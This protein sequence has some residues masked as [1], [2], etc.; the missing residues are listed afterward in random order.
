M[1]EAGEGLPGGPEDPGK[2]T[3]TEDVPAWRGDGGPGCGEEG[4]EQ[5]GETEEELEALK[6]QAQAAEVEDNDSEAAAEAASAKAEELPDGAI[7]SDKT[8]SAKEEEDALAD[9]EVE[10]DTEEIAAAEVPE[11]VTVKPANEVTG[12]AA[13]VEPAEVEAAPDESAAGVDNPADEVPA[14]PATEVPGEA[15]AP[16]VPTKAPDEIPAEPLK[17]VPTEVEG[18]TDEATAAVEPAEV[19]VAIPAAEVEEA[20]TTAKALDEETV[21]ENKNEEFPAATTEAAITEAEITK[22]ATTKA[23][24]TETEAAPSELKTEEAVADKT[25]ASAHGDKDDPME[26]AETTTTNEEDPME[27]AETASTEV[28]TPDPEM[29][30]ATDEADPAAEVPP[31]PAEAAAEV[32]TIV[33]DKSELIDFKDNST[34]VGAF[35][36]E[37][38]DNVGKAKEAMELQEAENGSASED[39]IWVQ[40]N[41]L[42]ENINQVDAMQLSAFDEVFEEE[43]IT[44]ITEKLQKNEQEVAGP[45]KQYQQAIK[46]RKQ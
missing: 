18:A 21:P 13:D 2:T 38:R 12:V 17:V 42:K 43:A 26:E 46:E 31:L 8:T 14:E 40:I 19:E 9:S 24:T 11:E 1:G 25:S 10:A 22:A 44:E 36:K 37:E 30:A 45:D 6:S 27:E 23:A 20:V 28:D 4:Q 41:K 5:G 7:P 16:G 33:K 39:R 35:V 15:A 34:E 29:E 3:V 32:G